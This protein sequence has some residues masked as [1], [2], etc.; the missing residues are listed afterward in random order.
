MAELIEDVVTAHRAATAVTQPVL[1]K[2]AAAT[3]RQSFMSG[4]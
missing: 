4:D 2:A 1:V 3:T